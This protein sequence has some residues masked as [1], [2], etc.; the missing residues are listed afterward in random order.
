MLHCKSQLFHISEGTVTMDPGGS[1]F[2]IVYTSWR[3]SLFL[4]NFPFCMPVIT[5]LALKAAKEMNRKAKY[6]LL[7]TSILWIM[8]R[9]IGAII[10]ADAM[11]KKGREG[12]K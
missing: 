12:T 11:A 1:S 7:F 2:P 3:R 9:T 6:P 4:L 10:S 8:E 5:M